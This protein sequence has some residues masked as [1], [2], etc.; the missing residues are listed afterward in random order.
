MIP[1]PDAGLAVPRTEASLSL[2]LAKKNPKVKDLKKLHGLYE[3]LAPGSSMMKS[4]AHTSIIKEPGKREVTMR[5]SDLAKF[6]TKAER[7]ID[8]QV[9]AYR[10]PKTPSGKKQRI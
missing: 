5:K 10:R 1:H 4:D 8:L 9:Y 6:G 2:K 7:Q 3:V